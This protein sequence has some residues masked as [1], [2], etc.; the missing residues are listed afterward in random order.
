M[1]TRSDTLL[2]EILQ[3]TR[4]ELA[5]RRLKRPPAELEAEAAAR[6]REHGDGPPPFQRA[7]ARPGIGVVAEFKRRS[8]SAGTIVEGARVEEIAVAYEQ[9][10]ASAL[11][12][13]TEE[14]HFDGSLEDLGAARLASRLPILRKDFIVDEYQLLE[15]LLGGADAV[16][17]IAAALDP[18]ELSSRARALGLEVLVEVHDHPELDTALAAGPAIIGINNR[19]LRDF[20]VDLER[21]SRLV[22]DIPD[23]VIIVS[24]SGIRS[25]EQVAELEQLGV[26][27]VLVGE[28]LMRSGKP[29]QAIATLLASSRGR[30]TL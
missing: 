29:Q 28:S 27:A 12:V 30:T 4:D 22:G 14:A 15:A 11:S 19:D 21:T 20:T 1:S 23:G 2:E 9:G 24:E 16:L 8:P 7:L 10:G 13:L 25:P 26:H 18:S 6:P 17:L 5:R 3:S